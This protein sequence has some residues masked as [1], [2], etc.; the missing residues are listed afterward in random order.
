MG[1]WR[2]AKSGKTK[3]KKDTKPRATA[4]VEATGAPVCIAA[5]YCDSAFTD[6]DD[7]VTIVR[8]ID[9][10]TF[11]AGT[12]YEPGE[13]VELGGPAKLVVM[14]KRDDATGLHEMPVDYLGPSGEVDLVGL[15]RQDFPVTVG[16]EEGYNYVGPIQVVW[17]GQ[18][19]YW[20]RIHH[21]DKIIAKTALKLLI[22]PH[23]NGQ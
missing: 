19:L 1:A 16:P 5:L 7:N 14:L 21:K 22:A 12:E 11:P 8:T 20:L 9:T 4:P 13:H 15:V 18:G 23:Q 2:V 6:K 17:R 10:I 3:S